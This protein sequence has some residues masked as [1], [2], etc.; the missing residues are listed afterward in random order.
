VRVHDAELNSCKQIF[1]PLIHV[2][3]S[4]FAV[5]QDSSFRL[6]T[7]MRVVLLP[8][9]LVFVVFDSA[10]GENTVGELREPGALLETARP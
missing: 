1:H 2:M 4:C 3:P 9:R 5:D 7:E 10:V 8:R 6:H